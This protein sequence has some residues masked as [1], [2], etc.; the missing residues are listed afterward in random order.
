MTKKNA[1]MVG[2]LSPTQIHGAS[3]ISA[4]FDSFYS[5]ETP[6]TCD[7]FHL[8]NDS[9]YARLIQFVSW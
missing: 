1:Y 5:H 9:C 2:F 8:N 4:A 7:T 3:H 6:E